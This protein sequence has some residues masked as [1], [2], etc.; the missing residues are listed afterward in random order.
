MDA[1]NRVPAGGSA[2]DERGF[3]LIEVLAAMFIL[4]LGIAAAGGIVRRSP[5]SG[6]ARRRR[7]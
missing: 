3:S 5:C 6:W 4:T 7:C 1:V 2:Q